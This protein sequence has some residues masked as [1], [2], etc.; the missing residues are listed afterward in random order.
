MPNRLK[1]FH[2][3]SC[4]SG[5]PERKDGYLSEITTI[6]ASSFPRRRASGFLSFGYFRQIAAALDVRISAC[7]GMTG[8]YSGLTKIRT[9]R[10]SRRQYK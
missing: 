4:E 6:F 10:R 5:Y 1:S 9:R 8:F 3:H 7:A 2:L